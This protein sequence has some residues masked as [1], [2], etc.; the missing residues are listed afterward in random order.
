MVGARFIFIHI[1]RTGGSSLERILL[2]LESVASWDEMNRKGI[3][4]KWI[5]PEKHIKASRVQANIGLVKW[6]Q[7]VKI[8]IVRNPFDKVISHYFQPFYRNINA[9]S[10]NTLESFLAAYQPPPHED[11]FTCSDYLD[12]EL[13]VIIRYENYANELLTLLEPF[14]V[15]PTQIAERIGSVRSTSGYREF[16]SPFAR[17]TV[18]DLY[19]SDLERFRYSF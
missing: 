15:T 18:E 10:G 2:S 4:D 6:E 7:A 19:A 12:K 3:V 8:S 13:D 14:G 9:L 16:Y 1:P 17:R 5:G 11:G